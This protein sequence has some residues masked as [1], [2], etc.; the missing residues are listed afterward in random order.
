MALQGELSMRVEKLL[1][2]GQRQ[3]ARSLAHWALDRQEAD[4][5]GIAAAAAV[6]C[7][8]GFDELACA[9][10]SRIHPDATAPE[11]MAARCLVELRVGRDEEVGQRLSAWE[12]LLAR[13]SA[14]DRG[15]LF[16]AAA[17]Y[18]QL[19]ALRALVKTFTQSE[20]A[21]EGGVGKVVAGANEILAALG[22]LRT[23]S[24]QT[25]SRQGEAAELVIAT[26][27]PFVLSVDEPFATCCA[28]AEAFIQALQAAMPTTNKLLWRFL[29]RFGRGLPKLIS[30][31]AGE[32]H[33]PDM[34]AKAVVVLPDGVLNQHS[35]RHWLA[36][37]RHWPN[38]IIIGLQVHDPGALSLEVTGALGCHAPIG[39]RDVSSQLLLEEC[40]VK[41]YVSGLVQSNAAI[42]KAGVRAL[43]QGGADRGPSPLDVA[44]KILNGLKVPSAEPA[45]PIRR[46][47]VDL[48]IQ[49]SGECAATSPRW[50]L[51]GSS[52][53][54]TQ[55]LHSLTRRRASML[56]PMGE[57]H[58]IE[59]AMAVDQQLADALPVVIESCI[60][61][62]SRPLRFHVLTR[63]IGV[64]QYTLWAEL[65]RGRAGL[66]CYGF[67]DVDYGRELHL[68]SHT[69][70]ST[71]D[72][73]LL[74][75]LL[76]QLARLI[77]LDVDLVV[78]GDLAELWTI[79][80]EGRPL[81]AKPSSSPGT[82]WG[83]QMLYQALGSLPPERSEPI[84]CWL[85]REGSMTFR[86]FN[87]GVL[88]LNL[89]RM[90][91]DHA[92]PL[93]LSLVEHAA[94]ND[95]DALNAYARSNYRPLE[96]TWNAAP[97]Q[98]NTQGAKI[99]H[100]VGPVKPW[101]DLYIS[102]KPEFERV[103]NRVE[104]RCR[105]LGLC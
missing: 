61:R 37:L 70:V 1:K 34:T 71:L 45:S 38:V 92:V 16:A 20:N 90:R 63:G 96:T 6:A 57:Q 43:W 32:G 55:L 79:D 2:Q 14:D 86:A 53:D 25:Y 93:M 69:T 84:R 62:A 80:L 59:V 75:L 94:M 23:V 51:P 17:S 78:M 12:A 105:E 35:A 88:V 18:G 89:D 56:E 99:I 39:V 13:V 68:I 101:H 74:P 31:C 91:R 21:V 54:L 27:P 48:T 103:R 52:V 49:A 33:V 19:A 83:I 97:R 44:G 81:A 36:A 50:V 67:D 9:L 28:G 66:E 3:A 87:A 46:T 30:L 73:L 77:Y 95:Q 64:S 76:P 22:V 5:E 102:R 58:P 42:R 11:F 60:E 41:S 15:M 24:H 65:L 10:F 98:D 85:H 26:L 82:H 72:R 8:E 4:S 47:L 100:F 40:G 7:A 29:P 104:L